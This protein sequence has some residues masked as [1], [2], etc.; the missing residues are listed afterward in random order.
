[1]IPLRDTIAAYRVQR[2]RY[3]HDIDVHRS[4]AET[5]RDLKVDEQ[6]QT[7]QRIV[8]SRRIRL[9]QAWSDLW[10]HVGYS[11]PGRLT[12]AGVWVG[13][14]TAVVLLIAGHMY[15]LM[16][17]VILAFAGNVWWEMR[18]H[19]AE[20]RRPVDPSPEQVARFDQLTAARRGWSR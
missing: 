18:L 1:M 14:I 19:A 13:S 15:A 20:S 5:M 17:W 7:H 6:V 4:A 8:N 16:P 11:L 9:E 12:R 3:M 10:V 2:T